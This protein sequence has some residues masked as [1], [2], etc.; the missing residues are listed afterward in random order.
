MTCLTLVLTSNETKK[1][2]PST[3]R[4]SKAIILTKQGTSTSG[5]RAK[6][7]EIAPPSRK[8]RNLMQNQTLRR[9]LTRLLNRHARQSCVGGSS[10]RSSTQIE[11]AQSKVWSAWSP[12]PSSIWSPEGQTWETITMQARS[13][14]LPGSRVLRLSWR[15]RS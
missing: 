3:W 5:K 7:Q 10:K 4:Q 8:K 9:Y 13:R 11:A 14:V 15:R 6:P 2:S 12:R 1:K